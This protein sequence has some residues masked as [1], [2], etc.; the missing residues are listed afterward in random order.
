MRILVA[1]LV[2]ALAAGPA[3]AQIGGFNLLDSP[4]KRKTQDDVDREQALDDAYKSTMKKM[5]DQKKAANDPWA[6]V[7]G[8]SQPPAV[9]KPARSTASSKSN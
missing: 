6:D 7:R 3:F 4:G 5:P 8:G 9:Q 1:A 2:L